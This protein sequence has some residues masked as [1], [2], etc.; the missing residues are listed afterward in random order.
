VDVIVELARAFEFQAAHRLPMV[1]ADHKCSRMHGH[2]W[3]AT[4]TLRGEIDEAM[5]WLCDYGAI[6]AFWYAECHSALDH[7]T[8]NDTLE[9]P[10]SENVAAWILGRCTLHLR[11]GR[12]VR[13]TVSENGRSSATVFG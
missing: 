12:D 6:D 5:G 3:T 7:Q 4:I 2:T 10:T 8:L 1:P 13:V 9:N 11:D